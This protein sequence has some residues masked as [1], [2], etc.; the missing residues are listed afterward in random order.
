MGSGLDDWID[1]Y[2]FAQ[3]RTTGNYSAIAILHTS[4]LTIA[5]ALEFSVFASRTLTT[6]LWQE[7][8]LQISVKY[9][10]H[11]LFSHLGMPTLQNS[12]QFSKANSLIYLSLSL[13]P[14]LRPTVSRPVCLGMKHPFGAYKQ[15]FITLRQLRV[16]WCGAL[17]PTGERICRLQLLLALASA[18]ILGSE[19]RGTRDHILLPQIRDFPFPRLLRLAGLRWRYSTPPPHGILATDSRFIDSAR[20][21]RKCVSRVKM[22]RADH[23]ENTV[24]SLVAKACLER[25]CLA[26][27]VLLLRARVLWEWVYQAVA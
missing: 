18:A 4:Q 6:D 8:S 1:T 10:C 26:I 15:I 11:F 19:S 22:R 9:S 3:F 24:S 13:S 16:C 17:S 12:T 2:T 14:T 7:L 25:R 20:T 23:V 27:E 21:Y 5:H